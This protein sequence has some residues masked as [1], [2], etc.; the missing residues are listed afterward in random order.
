MPE[1]IMMV[2][3]NVDDTDVDHTD[4]IDN[5]DEENADAT[6]ADD[7][8]CDENYVDN[9]YADDTNDYCDHRS[10][11]GDDGNIVDGDDVDCEMDGINFYNHNGHGNGDGTILDDDGSYIHDD[12]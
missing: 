7:K 11:N 8:N 3:E 4:A 10:D 6:N 1:I 9:T 2:Y 12:Y 5:A